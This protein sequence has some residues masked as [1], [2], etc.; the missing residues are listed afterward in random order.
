MSELLYITVSNQ[1]EKQ[2]QEGVLKEKDRLSERKLAEK[3]GVS[4]TVV[5][6][7]LK[8]LNEKGLV[9]IRYGKGNFV[10][11]PDNTIVM[12]KFASSIN[13]SSLK[14][15]DVV[16]AREILE[17]AMATYI[18]DRIDDK[19][20]DA[21][22]KIIEVMET[23]IDDGEAY[24]KLDAE[25]HALLTKAIKNEVLELIMG[26]LNNLTNRRT[27]YPSIE[28]R[29]LTHEE[30]KR[31]FNSLKSRDGDA[32]KEAVMLHIVCARDRMGIYFEPHDRRE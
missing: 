2:I 6:E 23:A 26:A 7:A 10:C 28:D 22:S 3:Y 1:I 21:M 12:D 29:K 16:E 27:L 25:F 9:E 18:T 8:L 15:E 24:A 20:I 32:L 31:I 4:R 30:H 13:N 11:V 14:T 5:R 19:E 17:T